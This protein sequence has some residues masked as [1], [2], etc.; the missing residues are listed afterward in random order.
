MWWV[1]LPL[2]FPA[3]KPGVSLSV[4]ETRQRIIVS[5]EKSAM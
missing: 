2:P 5:D 3:V 1:C 4:V